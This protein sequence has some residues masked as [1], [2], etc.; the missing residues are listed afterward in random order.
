M[1]IRYGATRFVLLLGDKAY[2]FGRVR[3]FRFLAR[4]CIIPFSQKRR[5][6][7]FERYGPG[8]AEA[9][10]NDLFAG[11]RANQNEYAYYRAFKD[12]R[13]MPI[14]GFLLEGWVI[15]QTRGIPVSHEEI[16]KSPLAVKCL[17]RQEYD[18][19]GD[20]QFCSFGDKV[21]LVDYGG[22]VTTDALAAT[23]VS[24]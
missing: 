3:P 16:E 1:R 17:R 23:I 10:K 22:K 14:T 18:L 4:M 12:S 15:V 20:H 6:H 13:V 21:V 24:C 8:F 7:F 2:K 19:C 9:V 11:L 5:K